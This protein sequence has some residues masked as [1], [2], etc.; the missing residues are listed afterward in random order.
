MWKRGNRSRSRRTTF[1]P[2]RASAVAVLEPPGP[3]P[4][5]ATSK[6]QPSLAVFTIAD[7]LSSL[8]R[9]RLVRR[10]GKRPPAHTA[11]YL[12]GAY[13]ADGAISRPSR[14]RVTLNSLASRPSG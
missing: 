5:T 9:L 4:M 3:P 13:F 14:K 8:V 11:P 1:R 12:G 10:A 6:S 2:A 7:D